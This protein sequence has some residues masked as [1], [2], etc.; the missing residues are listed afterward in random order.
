[1]SS[2]LS[3]GLTAAIA[4]AV[5]YGAAPAV[6]AVA[7]RREVQGEGVGAR[8]TL[9]LARR[10]IWL[11][12]MAIDV[13]GFALE[14]FAFSRAPATL[15]APVMACDMIV[16]VL[17]GSWLFR[18]R[19]SRLGLFGIGM[20]CVGVIDLG[21]VFSGKHEP[22]ANASNAELLFFL[23]GAVG[24]CGA[25][26]LIGSRAIAAGR[27]AFAAGVFA[28]ASGIAFG[29][30]TMATRQ[31]G[32][33]FDPGDPWQLLATPT[34]YVLAG[35]SLL[36]I[37]LTQRGL[38]SNP[39]L[40]FPIVSAVAAMLPV[41]IAAAILDDQV[42]GGLRRL[43]FVVALLLIAGGVAFLGRDRAAAEQHT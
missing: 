4:G 31:V 15:V 27:A 34:P 28:V 38:Q 19:L 14:A 12:G 35:C 9:R 40:T 43:A 24:V 25:G 18:E 32:R 21:L 6:Q 37:T 42:P 5:C 26:A 3:A 39:L 23:A 7:A 22:G 2:T 1:M 10:P 33:A 36:A 11:T 8:L 29:L 16:F 20:I 17:V 30:A 13:G 41:G